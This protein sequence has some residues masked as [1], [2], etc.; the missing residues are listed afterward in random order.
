MAASGAL[1]RFTYPRAQLGRGVGLNAL[2]GAL[3]TATGPIMA[4]ALR[5]LGSW[6]ILFLVNLPIGVIAFAMGGWALPRHTVAARRFDFLSA[7]CNAFAFGGLFLGAA[8]LSSGPAG[9]PGEIALAVSLASF[10][11]LFR[12]ARAQ[13]APLVPIDLLHVKSLRLSYAAS[14]C[15]FAAQAMALISL[16]FYF[17]Q[18]LGFGPVQT[19]LMIIT[20]WPLAVVVVA[21]I[22]GRLTERI[23]PGTMGGIG[24]AVLTMGLL[25]LVFVPSNAPRT[26]TATATAIAL[27]GAGFAFFQTPNNRMMLNLAS[28][29]RSAAA[30]G[31]LAASRMIPTAS[32]APFFVAAAFAVA[33]VSLRRRQAQWGPA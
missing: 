8:A 20:P 30:A 24:L 19:G 16:P 17:Q 32:K 21:P 5:T 28:V 29:E 18:R 4:A 13:A 12:K 26:A 1:V 14:A 22:A 25:G 23:A 6:R 9:P 10:I 2:M 7:L 11:V 15:S 27:C 31:M 3:S 33:L